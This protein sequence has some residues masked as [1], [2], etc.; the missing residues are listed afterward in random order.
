MSVIPIMTI[1][2]MIMNPIIASLT[3]NPKLLITIGS[4][5]AIIGALVST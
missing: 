1:G 3:I 4:S 5:F 2:L